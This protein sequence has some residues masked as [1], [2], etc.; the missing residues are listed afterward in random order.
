MLLT[1]LYTNTPTKHKN[2]FINNT[3]S[4]KRNKNNND[5]AK[6]TH[7]AIT[8]TAHKQFHPNIHNRISEQQQV[9]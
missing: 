7:E 6:R 1:I 4:T 5:A 8:D 9:Q 2:K 3:L